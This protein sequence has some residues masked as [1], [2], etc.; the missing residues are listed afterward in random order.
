MGTIGARPAGR[1]E[2]R[3]SERPY[4]PPSAA[5][6]AAAAALGRCSAQRVPS[7]VCSSMPCTTCGA[8]ASAIIRSS[9]E[10]SSSSAGSANRTSYPS[11]SAPHSVMTCAA[12]AC[13][14]RVRHGQRPWDSW[15]SAMSGS[16]T[17]TAAMRGSTGS[18]SAQRVAA[19]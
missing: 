13:S 9:S 3:T 8:I 18:G 17:Y 1:P 15:N 4:V 19:S 2:P 11:S 14:S 5:R 16:P 10:P 12:I 7:V 6:A